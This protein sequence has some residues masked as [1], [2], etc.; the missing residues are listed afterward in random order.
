[1]S[2]PFAIARQLDRGNHQFRIYEVDNSYKNWLLFLAKEYVKTLTERETAL[3]EIKLEEYG[4][5]MD[6]SRLQQYIRRASIPKFKAGL[7]NVVRSDFGELLCYILLER[8]YGTIFG[9]K[10]IRYRELRDASGR[11][12]D[13]IGIELRDKL[14][15]VL[16]EVKVSDEVV[17]PPQV[18]DR[19]NDCLSKQQLHHLAQLETD[20]KDKVWHV[21]AR[22]RNEQIELLLMAAASCLE[23]KRY[24]KLDIVVSN[25]LVR[26]EAT[27]KETDF[28]SFREDLQLYKPANIRFLLLRTPGAIESIIEQWY[29]MIKTLEVSE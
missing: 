7:F 27:C 9:A 25:V 20:T 28:G 18:V 23:E 26:S 22:T 24:D 29:E 1:M 5:V 12:I 13:A 14:T 17:S 21:A 10:S 4:L 19:S 15:L 3:K 8:N 16:C 11:G 2:N 6:T